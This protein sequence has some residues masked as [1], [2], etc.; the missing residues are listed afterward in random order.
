M[1]PR[2]TKPRECP[3]CKQDYTPMRMGQK[4]CIGCISEYI[5]SNPKPA[6]VKK[7]VQRAEKDRDRANYDHVCRLS[8]LANEAQTA[9]NAYVR[10][11]DRNDP[12]ISCGAPAWSDVDWHASHY[13]SRGGCTGA[14]FLLW[15][16]HKSCMQCNTHKHGNIA[17]YKPQ[18]LAKI[19]P[20]R[21]SAVES[22]PK[23]KRYERDYLIRLRDVFRAVLAHKKRLMRKLGKS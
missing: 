8:D 12:C 5:K 16:I 10:W 2:A 1:L 9:I 20:E 11:R 6:K 7:I 21:M 4:C 19:G 14:R 22:A 18:L 17:E 23:S 13:R 15:N 3:V